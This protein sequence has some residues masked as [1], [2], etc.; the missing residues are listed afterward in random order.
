MP[1]TA[2]TNRTRVLALALGALVAAGIWW[3]AAHSRT[4]TGAAG[5]VDNQLGHEAL[6][7]SNLLLPRGLLPPSPEPA[8]AARSKRRVLTEEEVK[9]W[10][11]MPG[12]ARYD[13]ERMYR[14]TGNVRASYEW[15]AYPGGS[16]TRVTNA[17]GEREDHEFP[18]NPPDVFVL[19]TGDSQTEGFCDNAA[20]YSNLLERA[21]A[22]SRPGR[23]VEV[24]NTGE[25]GYSFYNYLGVLESSLAREPHVFVTTF[26]AGNDFLEVVNVQHLYD[27]TAT[28]PR[29]RRYAEQ[30]KQALAASELALAPAVNELLYL[31][32]NP[33]EAD[34]ALRAACFATAEIQRICAEHG[35]AW[36]PVYLPSPFDL[37]LADWAE[38]RARIQETLAFSAADLEAANQLGD[39]LLATLRERGVEPLDL[40]P[41]FRSD[42]KPLYW[43]EMHINLH[44]QAVVAREL[45]P[46]VEAALARRAAGEPRK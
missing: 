16:W 3:L 12:F 18:A 35:I 4:R 42:P 9:R 14:A 41:V 5:L 26:Y 29:T 34:L 15:P 36:I 31:R 8:A 6:R 45:L 10:V 13:P 43:S 39:R 32:E 20:S 30:L 33:D 37:P 7:T 44:G 21:L 40:R 27:G 11:W 23:S 25:C 38:L 46:R 2:A 28:P 19:V 24:Y 1:S 22:A 17:E